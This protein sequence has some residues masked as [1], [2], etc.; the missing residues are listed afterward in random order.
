MDVVKAIKLT[1]Y[2]KKRKVVDSVSFRVKK[3]EIFGLLGK[4]GAGKSTIINMLTGIIHP[5]SGDVY[6]FNRQLIEKPVKKKIGVLP[7]YG[8]FYES[9]TAI[10]HLK[11]FSKVNGKQ[12]S[13]EQIVEILEQVGLGSDIERKVGRFSFGMKKKLGIA[14]AIVTDPELIFFD[15][16]TSGLDAESVIE[17]Q[18]LIR[19]LNSE[20]KTIFMTSHNL[21]EVE[22]LCSRIAILKETQLL[23]IGTM[24]EL[25]S[26]YQSFMN[27]YIRHSSFQVTKD[28]PTRIYIASLVDVTKWEEQHLH[29]V[30][31]DEDKIP[32]I[33][34][35]LMKENVDVYRVEVL[36]PSLEEIFLE[37]NQSSKV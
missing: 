17:I 19:R 1:K 34:R 24:E 7:D 31:Q 29:I 16:P 26:K 22:K 5:T 23:T 35:A 14:Q 13:T 20:G 8:S 3:G 32:H 12:I 25:R 27:V 30:T 10:E 37:Y 6:L 2:Y 33:L 28:H 9:L 36:E 4:N 15:E 18:M 11:Y 21:D